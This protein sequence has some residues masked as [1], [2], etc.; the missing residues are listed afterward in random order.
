MTPQER[1]LLQSL[2]NRVSNTAVPQKDPEADAMIRETLGSKP[3]ALYVLT[4]TVLIQEMA[5]NQ[6]NARLHELEQQHNP[7][8]QPTSFLGKLFGTGARPAPPQQQYAQNAPPQ[9]PPQY[10]AQYA[11]PQYGPYDGP[12]YGNPS[13]A[14]SFLRSAAA[15]ATGVAA[16][17][18]AFEGIES[19]LGHHSGYGAGY[20]GGFG[21][22]SSFLGGAPGETVIN[23]YYDGDRGGNSERAES[24]VR[25]SN[26]RYANMADDSGQNFDSAANQDDLNADD[27]SYD[28][29]GV[30]SGDDGGSYDD[31]GG[32]DTSV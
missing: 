9:M 20:G 10:A 6:A 8:P 26:D 19:L 11:P 17:A 27:V 23:N 24:D 30:S 15:T 29:S 28:D 31:L 32:G 22:G 5:L 25:D 16:G 4:Q 21:G 14:P 13:G 18:L 7:P 1:D 3:D 2:A 12:P